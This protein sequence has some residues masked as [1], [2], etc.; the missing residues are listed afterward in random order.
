MASRDDYIRYAAECAA[1]ARR[2][3]DPD[4]RMRLLEMAQA[5]RKLADK[6]QDKEPE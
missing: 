5:W 4:A 3:Q 6:V 2:A 1:L